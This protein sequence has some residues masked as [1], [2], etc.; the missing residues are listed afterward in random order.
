MLSIICNLLYRDHKSYAHQDESNAG[1][2]NFP[3]EVIGCV[4]HLQFEVRSDSGRSYKVQAAQYLAHLMHHRS[5]VHISGSLVDNV[6]MAKSII[7]LG[8]SSKRH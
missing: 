5:R 2:V 1:M 8:N 7:P 6:V 4:G 3:C